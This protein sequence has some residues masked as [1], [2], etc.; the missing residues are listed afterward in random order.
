M[1][2]G[3]LNNNFGKLTA[4]QQPQIQR[5]VDENK[6]QIQDSVKAEIQKA[7]AQI[8]Q[9]TLKAGQTDL[10]DAFMNK[11]GNAEIEEQVSSNQANSAPRKI[12]RGSIRN[13]F[14]NLAHA[15]ENWEKAHGIRPE[16]GQYFTR[17]E[18]GKAPWTS[19]GWY[20]F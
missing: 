2:I 5:G 10:T 16:N 13:F 18:L 17:E 3:N 8:L 20:H 14:N 19:G 9:G 6:S 12:I 7:G 15:I 1:G 4:Q 11:I